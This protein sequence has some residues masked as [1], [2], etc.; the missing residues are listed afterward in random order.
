MKYVQTFE[1]YLTEAMGP[2]MSPEEA[3]FRNIQ[4]TSAKINALKKEAS[5]KPEQQNYITAKINVELEKLDM[6][7]AK[8]N[9]LSAK[10]A[11]EA[12]KESEKARAAAEKARTAKP[13]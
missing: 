12:R 5:E 3:I 6:L 2:A 9:L 8:K 1:D 4:V 7:A 11:E 10:K 13:K